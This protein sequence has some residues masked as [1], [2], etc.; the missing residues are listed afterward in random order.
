M[1]IDQRKHTRFSLEIPATIVSKFGDRQ[2]TVLQQISIGGCFT[3]WEENIY[4]GDEFRLEIGLPNGN[5]LPLSC[6]AVYRFDNTGVGVKFT[7]ISRFEQ[8]LISQIIEA[9]LQDE[10]L[11]MPIDPFTVPTPVLLEEKPRPPADERR[12]RED[13]L[14][15]IMSYD[16]RA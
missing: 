2:E 12:Q 10:G 7:D 9:K 3:G 16:D 13:I 6:K 14:E 1:S 8:S 11:P 5:R 4:T 15:V